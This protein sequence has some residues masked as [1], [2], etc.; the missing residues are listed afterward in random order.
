MM[1]NFDSKYYSVPEVNDTK[2]SF[3]FPVSTLS[4][5]APDWSFALLNRQN[6]NTSIMEMLGG[7]YYYVDTY[8]Q[9]ANR[10]NNIKTVAERLSNHMKQHR[11]KLLV[12]MAKDIDSEN[13]KEAY[14]AYIEANN[15]LEGIVALQYSPYAAGA[16]EIF[17]F[18]NS[19]GYD[20]PVVTTKY[21][22]WDRNHERENNPTFIA[23]KLKENAKEE[24]YSAICVHAW[25]SFNGENGAAVAKQCSDQL[26]DRFEIVNMQELIW[27]IRM[28]YKPDQTKEYLNSIY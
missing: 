23:N 11:I 28:S 20:I 21:S 10:Q 5:M 4:M 18:K 6:E 19:D 1:Q 7:G 27:R 16:G 26:D 12:V 25:S 17:W 13:A 15:Q 8:S 3:G 9:N 24:T 22:L 2:M 14:R